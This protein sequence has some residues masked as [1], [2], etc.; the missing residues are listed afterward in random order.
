MLISITI[1]TSLFPSFKKRN[2]IGNYRNGI[3]PNKRNKPTGIIILNI[4]C[5]LIP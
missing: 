2:E 4:K 5:I 1:T 3:I